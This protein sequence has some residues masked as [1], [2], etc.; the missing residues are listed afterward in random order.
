MII[1]IAYPRN[2]TQ[3]KFEYKEEHL[4]AK[5]YDRKLGEEV[6]GSQFGEGFDGYIFQIT[7]GNDKNGFSMKQGVAT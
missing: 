1:N 7:G 2:G 4:W 5:L 6:D 3:K